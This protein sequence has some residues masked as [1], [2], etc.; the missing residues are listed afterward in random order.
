[1]LLVYYPYDVV[2]N[3]FENIFGKP[4]SVYTYVYMLIGYSRIKFWI[5][6]L[7]DKSY[8]GYLTILLS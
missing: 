6:I 7:Y 5:F 4:I 1:M 2:K 3:I 8:F